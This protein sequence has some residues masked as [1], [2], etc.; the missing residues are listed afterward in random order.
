MV[1]KLL[2]NRVIPAKAGTHEH[3]MVR[4]FGRRPSWAP[5][6]AGVTQVVLA[7]LLAACQQSS[8]PASNQAAAAPAQ[9]AAPVSD[10]STAQ[11]RVLARLGAG[12]QVHF[13]N[14]RRSASEGVPVICGTY[15]QGGARQRYI[16][17]NGEDAFVEPQMR[18]GEMDRAVAEFCREGTDNRPP[19]VLP[20][21][22]NVQ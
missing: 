18:P 11:Q 3:G 10:V 21:P 19:P 7:P 2:A 17:V 22:E 6:F 5:A 1:V 20:V 8:A 9:K 12:A 16:V 4:I 13:L 14:V 15:E